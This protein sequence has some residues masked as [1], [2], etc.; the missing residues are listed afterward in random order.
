MKKRAYAQ[1]AL[2]AAQFAIYL[3]YRAVVALVCALPL[4]SNF[5][6]GRVLG[7]VCWVVA[8][9]YRRLVVE[10]LTIAFGGEKSPDE[11]RILA[12]EHFASLGANLLS[13][14][15]VASMSPAEIDA[16]L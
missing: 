13:S 14:F 7:T 10:N 16:L 8:W 11:I 5:K 15:K 2:E 4:E 12:R 9:P 6:L 1:Q 3:V